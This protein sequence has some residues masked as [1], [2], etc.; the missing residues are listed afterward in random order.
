LK[1][2]TALAAWSLNF[3]LNG[4][5]TKQRRHHPLQRR[6]ASTSAYTSLTRNKA[7]TTRFSGVE[8]STSAYNRLPE[9]PARHH[10]L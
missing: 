10:P 5:H 7:D 9:E 2:R 3:S 1:T 8:F 6:G 4:P